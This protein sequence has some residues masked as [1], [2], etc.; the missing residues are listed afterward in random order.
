VGTLGAAGVDIQLSV[1]IGGST[2]FALRQNVSPNGTSTL[3][4][5]TNGG[6][7]WTTGASLAGSG[8]SYGQGL[9]AL[10]DTVVIV[11]SRGNFYRST[12]SGSSF[13]LIL[14]TSGGQNNYFN[15]SSDGTYGVC[16]GYDQNV[17]TSNNWASA[18]TT[19]KPYGI[20]MATAALTN[21]G[22]NVFLHAPLGSSGSP[23]T[24]Y[25]GNS[26]GGS[27]I[28]SF[29]VGG[30]QSIAASNPT[31]GFNAF[32]NIPESGTSGYVY[33]ATYP[34]TTYATADLTGITWGW[35]GYLAVTPDNK[36]LCPFANGLWL[37]RPG[38]TPTQVSTFTNFGGVCLDVTG[39]R[40]FAVRL[41]GEVYRY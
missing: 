27:T 1:P 30:T 6:A 24:A 2:L 21:N 32:M 33:Y 16:G 15:I 17:I 9:L 22:S 10:S 11:Q 13:S 25:V 7:T 20:V 37:V 3:Y 18:S 12:D 29:A 40:N 26:S 34:S 5:S 35:T 28:K 36:I 39:A 23:S 38:T 41:S 19:S 14:S 31:T 8:S 4:R